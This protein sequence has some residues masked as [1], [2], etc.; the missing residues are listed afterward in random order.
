MALPAINL[1][2]PINIFRGKKIFLRAYSTEERLG[3]TGLDTKSYQFLSAQLTV[4]FFN[5]ILYIYIYVG[6]FYIYIYIYLFITF[7]A[8]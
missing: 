8:A 3:N 1:S 5:I 7:Y 2:W 4:S 6:R